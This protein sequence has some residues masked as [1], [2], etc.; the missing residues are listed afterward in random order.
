MSDNSRIY[1]VISK[2]ALDGKLWH[3]VIAKTWRGTQFVSKHKTLKAARAAIESYRDNPPVLGH[4]MR[5]K[6]GAG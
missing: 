1:A 3:V 6:E 5:A 4:V 2:T